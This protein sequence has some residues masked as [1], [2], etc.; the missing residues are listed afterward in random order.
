MTS[1]GG[2]WLWVAWAGAVCLELVHLY[3]ALV[4]SPPELHMGNLIRIM[5]FHVACAWTGLCAFFAAFVASVAYLWRRKDRW[6]DLAV[7]AVEIG[8]CF[9]TLTLITG[10]LW[11]R[12]I[13]NTWWT[14]DPRLTTTLILWFLYVGYLL[15][16]GTIPE[17]DRR[18]VVAAVWSVLS[19]A[20][21]PVI[22]LSVTWWRSIHPQVI[23]NAGFEMPAS[24]A[25]TLMFGFVS[26]MLI[27]LCLWLARA[28]QHELRRR[29]HRLQQLDG[30]GGT[31][32][33][34]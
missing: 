33:G 31:V 4:W 14:W 18:A 5:Y 16:R 1:F 24:M 8:V 20:D 28:R 17:S 15:L 9:I 27:G 13:W 34:G 12:P 11:A 25:F 10:S 6:D 21:V 19:F 23:D 2:R 32:V 26:F 22:H 7:S 29:I 3:L 30:D